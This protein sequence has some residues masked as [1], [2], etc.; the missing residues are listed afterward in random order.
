MSERYCHACV[1]ASSVIF[2]LLSCSVSA[3]ADELR[4]QGTVLAGTVKH[5]STKEVAFDTEYG[6]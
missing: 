6:E 1:A 2:I 3:W 4:S 5:V